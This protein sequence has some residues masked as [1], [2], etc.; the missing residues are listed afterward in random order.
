MLLDAHGEEMKPCQILRSNR[1]HL[2]ALVTATTS[3]SA[4]EAKNGDFEKN[5]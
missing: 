5:C 3:R 2:G 4:I 1:T